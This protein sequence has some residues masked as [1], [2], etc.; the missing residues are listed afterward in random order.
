MKYVKRM[1]WSIYKDTSGDFDNWAEC[2]SAH[3]FDQDINASPEN[4]LKFFADGLHE[5]HYGNQVALVQVT[6]G[7]FDIEQA[8]Q[9]I[10]E[11]VEADGYWGCYI[12]RFYRRNGKFEV[13]IGS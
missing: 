2:D 1:C 7:K 12:E 9:A 6:D 3:F 13:A 8:K 5:I 4:R 10:G 11:A